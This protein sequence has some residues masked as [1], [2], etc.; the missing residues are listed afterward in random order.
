MVAL[1]IV[2][3]ADGVRRRRTREAL[4]G[5]VP[6]VPPAE[7]AEGVGGVAGGGP[8]GAGTLAGRPTRR[9]LRFEAVPADAFRTGRI[10][11]GFEVTME[12]MTAEGVEVRSPRALEPGRTL[13]L[14]FPASPFLPA[15]GT[16]AG[17]EACVPDE[18]G[19][20]VLRLRFED[21]LVA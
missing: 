20:F 19:G 13:A 21:A 1:R 14:N 9:V 17:V 11:P 4:R 10:E 7:G 15:P 3:A 18:D 6:G 2:P 8:R 12:R 5:D 16:L